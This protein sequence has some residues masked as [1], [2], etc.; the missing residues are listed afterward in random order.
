MEVP[1]DFVARKNF[2]DKSLLQ[3]LIKFNCINLFGA[4]IIIL[5]RLCPACSDMCTIETSQV[6]PKANCFSPRTV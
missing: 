6:L 5:L 2:E 1:G 3:V 4:G